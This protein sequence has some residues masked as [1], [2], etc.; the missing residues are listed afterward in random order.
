MLRTWSLLLAAFGLTPGCAEEK[1]HIAVPMSG[2][3]RSAVLIFDGRV[4]VLDPLEP[5]RLELDRVTLEAGLL[6]FTYDE[7]LDQLGVVAGE[8]TPGS[9]PCSLL[10]PLERFR[11]GP[12]G[13]ELVGSEPPA[14]ILVGERAC[15]PGCREF[16]VTSRLEVAGADALTVA[17]IGS[18]T[19]LGDTLG[20]SRLDF[21]TNQLVRI[22]TAAVTGVLESADG[23]VWL[24][25]LG[26][27]VTRGLL[28]G[29]RTVVRERDGSGIVR[30]GAL[31]TGAV[32]ALLN[33]KKTIKIERYESGW[34]QE[35]SIERPQ[36]DGTRTGWTGGRDFL[37][38]YAADEHGFFVSSQTAMERLDLDRLATVA[39]PLRIQGA[40]AIG[41]SLV[42]S[43]ANGGIYSTRDPRGNFETL[44]P[45]EVG[46]GISVLLPLNRGFV[47]VHELVILM[48]YSD[49]AFCRNQLFESPIR[50]LLGQVESDGSLVVAGGTYGFE[51]VRF[52]A[53]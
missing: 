46:R 11:L 36:E 23:D 41:D 17:R 16:R 40:L 45:E 51:V 2:E 28:E 30:L 35:L 1:V 18:A 3:A 21:A 6:L 13:A 38:G 49:G 42:L 48:Q 27:R 47:A 26:G 4:L 31:P 29:S 33:V 15:S 20:F 50:P 44:K 24:A 19:Y 14:D 32:Y 8:L 9:G 37:F 7:G 10:S 12:S 34:V 53:R 22:S 25:E 43:T 52:E 39:P 5:I